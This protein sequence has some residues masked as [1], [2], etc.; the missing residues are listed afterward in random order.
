M[1]YGSHVEKRQSIPSNFGLHLPALLLTSDLLRVR[2]RG[3]TVFPMYLQPEQ[4][5]ALLPLAESLIDVF[6]TSVGSTIAEL[7]EAVREVSD[8][9]TDRLRVGGLVKL[10]RDRCEVDA[11]AQVDPVELRAEVYSA[12]SHHWQSL[13]VRDVFDREA[14]LARCA[15]AHGVSV[16]QLQA[17]MFADLP[18]AQILRDMRSI[19]AMQLLQRYNL[20]LA[21]GVLLRATRLKIQ[22]AP[23]TAPRFRQLMRAIK[24]RRLM[25][26]IEGSAQDGYEIELDGPMSLF[27]STQRYGLQ[28]AMF[29]P[30]LVA[31][32]G[33]QLEAQ[34]RWGKTRT[35]SVFR[36]KDTDGLVSDSRHDTT[37]LEEITQLF[38]TF[39]RLDSQWHVKRTSKVFHLK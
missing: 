15:S 2:I 1:G 16:E 23:T 28:L 36:L 37:E 10:L 6:Q 11:T 3:N 31:S 24:F 5:T 19:S 33:W 27:E 30:T 8:A 17:M 35:E 4:M 26:R 32:E 7:D 25:F 38:E 22:L 39:S 21:Q 20:A 9:Q 13:G 12:A 18:G 14:V 34:L 29:L